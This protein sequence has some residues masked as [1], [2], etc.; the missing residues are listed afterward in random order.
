MSVSG[1][2]GYTLVELLVGMTVTLVVL[3]AIMTIVQA[4]TRHQ[5]RVAEQV[6]ANQRARPA[7]TWIVD[8]LH[9]ACVSPGLAPVQEGSD[10]DTL[11]LLSKAGED[12]SPLPDKFVYSLSEG[13]LSETV[14]PG[15]GGEPEEW[16]FGS[17][18]EP[19][20][21][22]DGVSAAEVGEPPESVPVFRYY[23]YEG[24]EV[25][26]TPLATSP[27]GLS[28]ADAA[29][30]VQVDVAFT[31]APYASSTDASRSIAVTDSATLRIEPASEDSAEV[32]RPCV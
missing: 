25:S 7:M 18:S 31:A 17:P 15:T 20:A 21:V 14:Y 30:T 32:N 29:R 10:G 9:S 8:R 12:V 1:E 11:I 24:G 23:A 13:V 16:T 3:G 19:R 27:E 5:D 22:L 4:A 28:E 26:E 2:R 6:A